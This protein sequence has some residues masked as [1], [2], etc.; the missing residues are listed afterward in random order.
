MSKRNGS[1]DES[2]DATLEMEALRNGVSGRYAMNE[3]KAEP[4]AKTDDEKMSLFW[5]V[6]GGTI[7]SMAALAAL[8]L[9]NTI[10]SGLSELRAE[11]AKLNEAKV[12][13]AKKDE[14][15]ALRTQVAAHAEY[16][17]EIDSLK[18]RATKHRAEL[19]EVRKE[20]AAQLDAV[21]K[22][23]LTAVD[24]LKKDLAGVE[25]L[26]ERVAGVTTDSK[27]VK[28][29]LMKLRQD[30]DKNQ[31]HDLER[32]DRRDSQMKQLDETLKE[33]QKN[34]LEAR[35]KIA[36]LEGQ[37]T[38]AKPAVAA[39]A[40]V[41]PPALTKGTPGKKPNSGPRPATPTGDK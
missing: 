27:A 19:D 34:L 14:V 13:A 5:R 10:N 35:E 11:V 37:Q 18:E 26:K 20:A 1:G 21:K 22:E 4:A 24:S 23:K 28:D 12:D 9:Y 41:G 8:T 15:S 40:E 29:D 16:R 36:R 7:V 31:A 38:P 32:R 39:P 17:R 2:N 6:F 30:V 3:P 33:I 25:V